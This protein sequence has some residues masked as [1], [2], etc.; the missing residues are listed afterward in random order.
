[1]KNIKFVLEPGDI[2]EINDCLT[3][4][5]ASMDLILMFSLVELQDTNLTIEIKK[6]SEI[7]TI[8][9]L[10]DDLGLEI[11]GDPDYPKNDDSEQSKPIETDDKI[12]ISVN[13]SFMSDCLDIETN[14]VPEAVP[15]A[16]PEP[17]PT[18][19][20]EW[21]DRVPR[22]VPDD[23][24]M[25]VAGKTSNTLIGAEVSND[26]QAHDDDFDDDPDMEDW[27]QNEVEN[28][29]EPLHE[30][31]DGGSVDNHQE[32]S[33]VSNSSAWKTDVWHT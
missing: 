10:L 1:M 21:D 5:D 17:T 15:E 24:L 13:A 6:D 11:I 26:I 2:E 29:D 31:N 32:K 23:N 30:D 33:N 3:K 14:P 27:Y 20:G 8:D 22:P 12:K 18:D 28:D 9:E 4:C 19:G 7:N 25:S 16:V